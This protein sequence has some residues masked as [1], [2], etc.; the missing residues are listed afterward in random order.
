MVRGSAH[1]M[2]PFTRWGVL[3]VGHLGIF[4]YRVRL[5]AVATL[6]R[7][8]GTSPATPHVFRSMASVVRGSAHPM[9]TVAWWGGRGVV[10]AVRSAV[11]GLLAVA[12]RGLVEAVVGRLRPRVVPTMARAGCR[13]APP[14]PL[15]VSIVGSI[16]EKR[17]RGMRQCCPV[18]LAGPRG[19]ELS[20]AVP[21]AEQ[22]LFGVALCDRCTSEGPFVPAGARERQNVRPQPEVRAD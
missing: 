1:P 10:R 21:P 11:G 7:F 8:L 5:I 2:R 12:C 20:R 13:F 15:G 6:R 17:K 16:V 9:S 18:L 14:V 4:Q 19:H 22:C 3:G